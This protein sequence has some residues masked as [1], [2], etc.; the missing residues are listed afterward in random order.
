MG[1]GEDVTRQA[2]HAGKDL[3]E[4]SWLEYCRGEGCIQEKEQIHPTC[5]DFDVLVQG[6]PLGKGPEANLTLEG[7][8]SRV[9][10]VVVFQVFLGG[11]ALPTGFTHE[12]P[13]P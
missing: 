11:K 3:A 4:N 12:R 7:L 6:I 9:D 5:V 1:G 10:P 13:F 2:V 8:G